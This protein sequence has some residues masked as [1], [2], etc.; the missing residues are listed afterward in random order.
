MRARARAVD[1]TQANGRVES[2]RGRIV[3]NNLLAPLSN[4]TRPARGNHRRTTDVADPKKRELVN[5]N[6]RLQDPRRLPG[7]DSAEKTQG[8]ENV[9]RIRAEVY[10]HH[11]TYSR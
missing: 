11:P 10:S 3:A 4:Q 1:D 7:R 9:R 8:K 2:V 5:L 6:S